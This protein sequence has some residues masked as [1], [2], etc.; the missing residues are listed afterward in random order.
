VTAFDFHRYTIPAGSVVL[1]LREA[2]RQLTLND[3]ADESA[4][5][6]TERDM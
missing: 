3:E 1:R 2:F 5:S 6:V 4:A